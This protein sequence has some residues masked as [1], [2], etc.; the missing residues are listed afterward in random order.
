MSPRPAALLAALAVLALGAA[1]RAET[2]RLAIVV[3][4]NQG[5][6]ALTCRADPAATKRNSTIGVAESART[7]ASAPAPRARSAMAT[8]DWRTLTPS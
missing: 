6:G 7:G 1:A 8:S 2:H 5:D 3:G 4:N